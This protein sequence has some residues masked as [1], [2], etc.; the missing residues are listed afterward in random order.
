MT[1]TAADCCWLMSP[2]SSGWLPS[3]AA[4]CCVYSCVDAHTSSSRTASSSTRY[5]IVSLHTHRERAA[6]ATRTSC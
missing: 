6:T 3:G 4:V 5:A 2:S 1:R